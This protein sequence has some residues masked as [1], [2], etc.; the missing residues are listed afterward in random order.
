MEEG[1]E[2]DQNVSYA[3]WEWVGWGAGQGEGMGALGI[4]FEM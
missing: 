2:Y 4:A 3:I 1:D